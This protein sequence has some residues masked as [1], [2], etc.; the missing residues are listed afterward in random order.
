MG[1]VCSRG[2]GVAPVRIGVVEQER[3]FGHH[4]GREGRE[5]FLADEGNYAAS[6]ALF[7][8]MQADGDTLLRFAD[9]ITGMEQP[10]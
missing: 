6:N 9:I 5:E 4:V 7:Q 1:C 3:L 8:L 2:V 10:A